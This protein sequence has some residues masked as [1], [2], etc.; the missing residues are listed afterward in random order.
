MGLPLEKKTGTNFGPPGNS[1]LVYFLD[2]L[3]LSEVRLTCAV[4]R[5]SGRA[6]RK[7]RRLLEHTF[8]PDHK[9]KRK[10]PPPVHGRC[11][12][13]N[14][15]TFSAFGQG[16]PYNTQSA[17]AL[18]RQHMEYEHTYDLA[19]LSLKNIANTQVRQQI[20]PTRE[21]RFSSGNVACLASISVR[22]RD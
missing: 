5:T 18:L 9:T 1:R 22:L 21:R 12:P 16:D 10:L 3:N 8:S 6:T 11:L 19:K 2:D 14:T 17:I 4:H 15:C 7:L 13:I 20:M